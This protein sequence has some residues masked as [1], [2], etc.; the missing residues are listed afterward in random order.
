MEENNLKFKKIYV[1]V[2]DISCFCF[3]DY[4]IQEIIQVI[5]VVYFGY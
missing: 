2:T 5:L 1:L 3:T 4:A